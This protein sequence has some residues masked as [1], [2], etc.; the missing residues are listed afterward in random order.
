MNA[1]LSDHPA[2]PARSRLAAMRGERAPHSTGPLAVVVSDAPGENACRVDATLSAL[3]LRRRGRRILD[4][5]RA[6][7][8]DGTWTGVVTYA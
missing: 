4:I 1:Q 8:S 3:A 7:E 6:Q 2:R 5:T